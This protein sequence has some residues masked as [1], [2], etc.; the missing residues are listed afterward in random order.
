[1]LLIPGAGAPGFILPQAPPAE[2]DTS[3][4]RSLLDISSRLS[5]DIRSIN[6]KADFVP[7][8]G[9]ESAGVTQVR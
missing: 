5:G 9:E 6:A 8:C 1:M 4:T 2:I 7:L 3:K